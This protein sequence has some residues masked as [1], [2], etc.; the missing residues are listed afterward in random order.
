MDWI[1]RDGRIEFPEGDG[2]RIENPT[3]NVEISGMTIIGAKGSGIHIGG[4]RPSNESQPSQR[5][6]PGMEMVELTKELRSHLREL[7]PSDRQSAA[8]ILEQVEQAP[9]TENAHR[10]LRFLYDMAVSISGSTIASIL[11]SLFRS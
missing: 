9:T 11:Q 7:P 10:G 2:I 5:I 6:R 1:I 3:G 8:I 4:P